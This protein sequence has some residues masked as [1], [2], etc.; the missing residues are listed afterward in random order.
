VA[1][2][3]QVLPVDGLEGDCGEQGG[4]ELRFTPPPRPLDRITHHNQLAECQ[5]AGVNPA[6]SGAL[7]GDG[8]EVNW[9]LMFAT[10]FSARLAASVAT[11][12]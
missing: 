9:L 1:V 11:S 6:D 8:E 10:N 5:A 4:G 7:V 3:H 12:W 2:G